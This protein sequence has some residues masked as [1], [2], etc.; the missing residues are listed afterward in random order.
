[1]KLGLYESNTEFNPGGTPQFNER[2]VPGAFGEGI[3]QTLDKAASDVVDPLVQQQTQ[4]RER[5]IQ[6]QLNDSESKLHAAYLNA[7]NG[8]D[9]LKKKTGSDVRESAPDTRK[10]ISD[11]FT[12]ITKGE[13]LPHARDLFMMRS[14]TMMGAYENSINEYMN[15]QDKVALAA[16]T[17]TATA[18]GTAI[19]SNGYRDD[20]LV[21]KTTAQVESKLSAYSRSQDGGASEGQH[22][23]E[24]NKTVGLT[25]IRNYLKEN[26]ES[27]IAA[28]RKK[29][30][31]YQPVLGEQLHSVEGEINIAEEKIGGL[32]AALRAAADNTNENSSFVNEIDARSDILGND[33][34][35][36]TSKMFALTHLQSLA[37]EGTRAQV[38]ANQGSFSRI[39]SAYRNG[40]FGTIPSQD[41][42]YL[43]D[44]P[45]HQGS[46]LWQKFLNIVRED[47]IH[48]ENKPET[49]EERRAY[50][51]FLADFA[52]HKDKFSAIPIEQ[53]QADYHASF[54]PRR[55]VEADSMVS[56]LKAPAAQTEGLSHDEMRLV[57]QYGR[58]NGYF[59]ET[60]PSLWSP[61]DEL[62]METIQ[63]YIVNQRTSW[64]QSHPKQKPGPDEVQKWV[65]DMYDPNVVLK[66]GIFRDTRINAIDLSL[67]PTPYRGKTIIP[68][69]QLN[70]IDAALDSV[71]LS[72]DD[73]NREWLY[74]KYQE[75]NETGSK[76]P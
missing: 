9:G 66:S 53:F 40:G 74:R 8:P 10:I 52:A 34:L 33:K 32:S 14:K 5:L 25:V 48:A 44:Q 27:G 6:T 18:L 55:R 26:T 2:T 41:V 47:S 16:S 73:V 56:S 30:V 20:D 46:D 50:G 31:Q 72:H 36:P 23:Q 63:R 65:K 71:N 42:A 60:D 69:A 21:A 22:L 49:E 64:M 45:E 70:Q 19:I 28:A 37:G 13:M 15:E 51:A 67:N 54:N 1:M 35:T 75:Q 24:W 4:Q 29:L 62:R 3:D 59:K 57:L 68:A 17:R 43:R 58:T 38:Q 12:Q 76:A 7:M 11:A 61:Q 39:Y